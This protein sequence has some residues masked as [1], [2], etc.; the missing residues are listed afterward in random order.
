MIRL[1]TALLLL[2]S[3]APA[4]SGQGKLVT[5]SKNERTL[6]ETIGTLSAAHLYQAF[7]N[8]GMLADGRAQGTYNEKEAAEVLQTVVTLVKTV[9]AQLISVT[10]LEL[11]K[12]DRE[13]MEQL[14]KIS[15][16]LQQEADELSAF[17]KSGDEARGSKYQKLREEAWQS[18]SKVLGI[19]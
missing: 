14:R 7:L 10:K 18:L 15:L 6:L 1:I 16:L 13:A 11:A 12:E 19:K 2:V 9:D 3:L 4:V 5:T 17:W 8:I